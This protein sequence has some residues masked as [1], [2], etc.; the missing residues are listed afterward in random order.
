MNKNERTFNQNTKNAVLSEK[1]PKKCCKAAHLFGLL[2]FGQAFTFREIRHVTENE[3]ITERIVRLIGKL[4][5][6]DVSGGVEKLSS[7]Y[8]LTIRGE[9]AEKI[10]SYFVPSDAR[11]AYGIREELF[12]CDRCRIEFLKGAFL[13]CGNISDPEKS[14]HLEMTVAYFNLSRELLLFLKNLNLPAKYT[15]RGS[16][17]VVY[18]KD[19]ETIADFLGTIGAV[20]E[21]LGVYNTLATKDLRNR[22][23]RLN[24]CDTANLQ[25]HISAVAKQSEAIEALKARGGWDGLSEE[26]R[27]TAALRL[28][29]PELSLGELAEK[30]TPP[31]T[32]SCVNRRLNRLI[33]LSKE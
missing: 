16:H 21:N 28:E 19:S 29:N 17:Y 4:F 2:L 5:A 6:L 8:K 10:V 32:K 24:N 31:V 15:K 13:S 27:Y 7:Q 3:A 23:N 12:R 33:A 9:E 25:K 11:T 20:Q 18:Y 30:H 14:Y 26:L 22:I 1:L